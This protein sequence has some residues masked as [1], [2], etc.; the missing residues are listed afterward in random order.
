M[1]FLHTNKRSITRRSAVKRIV[2][3]LLFILSLSGISFAAGAQPDLDKAIKIGSGKTAVIEY[4]DPDCPF[5]RK[6]SAF[7][8]SRRD[9]TRYIFLNPLAMHPQAKE[10]AQYIL[11]AKDKAKAYEEVMS[12][13]LDG[14]QLS[15]IT[16]EGIKLQEEHQAIAKEAKV[17]STPTFIICGRII[18]GF[19]QRKLEAALGK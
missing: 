2:P 14:K 5:C 18:E 19:D 6:G 17:D 12:G 11:S 4:T 1:S 8:R 7:F 9:V 10:K 13:Q 16:R 3:A 15:G